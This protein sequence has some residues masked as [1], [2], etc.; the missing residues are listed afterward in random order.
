M[1]STNYPF[2][3]VIFAEELLQPT[4]EVKDCCLSATAIFP[5][6]IQPIM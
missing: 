1:D 4:S 2:S 6:Y 3:Q 5:F